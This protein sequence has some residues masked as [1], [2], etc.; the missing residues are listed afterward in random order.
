MSSSSNSSND[1]I[2]DKYLSWVEE[3]E[4]KISN[5]YAGISVKVYMERE[6]K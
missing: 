1:F 6:E 5:C 3:R 4:K 2:T